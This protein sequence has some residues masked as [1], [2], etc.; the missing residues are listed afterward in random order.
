MTLD[1][2]VHIILAS[3]MILFTFKCL[4]SYVF[5]GINMQLKCLHYL[6]ADHYLTVKLTARYENNFCASCLFKESLRTINVS[7]VLCWFIPG[8]RDSLSGRWNCIDNNGRW[9]HSAV[10]FSLI[11]IIFCLFMLDTNLRYLDFSMF[12]TSSDVCENQCL[13][14]VGPIRSPS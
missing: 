4:A 6:K 13:F 3:R 8:C 5:Y 14:G 12:C 9:S 10:T 1:N 7:L 2:N 11:F